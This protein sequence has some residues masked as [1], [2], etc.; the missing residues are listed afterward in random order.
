MHQIE[1]LF[2][3]SDAKLSIACGNK[4]VVSVFLTKEE[5]K[6]E[7]RLRKF[8]CVEEILQ[9]KDRVIIDRS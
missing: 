1:Q 7:R 4:N 5:K 9:K 2:Q 3:K 6:R 8:G